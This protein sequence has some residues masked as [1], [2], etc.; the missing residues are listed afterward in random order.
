MEAK[1]DVVLNSSSRAQAL[2]NGV[3]VDVTATANKVGFDIPVAL[4]VSA[5]HHYIAVKPGDESLNEENRLLDVLG[6]LDFVLCKMPEPISPS[7]EFGLRSRAAHKCFALK[8]KLDR[9]D[10][11]SPCITVMLPEED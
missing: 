10:D 7:F 5:W 6:I 3:L 8:V 1:Q 11:G 4:T 2:K 9:D